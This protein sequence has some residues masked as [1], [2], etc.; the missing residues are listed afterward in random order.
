MAAAMM[1]MSLYIA[2]LVCS[3]GSPGMSRAKMTK[4]PLDRKF[5]LSSL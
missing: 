2:Q 5:S 3:D 4:L 1:T